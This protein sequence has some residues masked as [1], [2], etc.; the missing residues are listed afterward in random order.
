M[1]SF[2]QTACGEDAV[3]E[4]IPSYWQCDGDNDC[5]NNSDEENCEEKDCGPYAFNCGLEDSGRLCV[6]GSWECDGDDDCG[7]GADEA[8][9]D[10]VNDFFLFKYFLIHFYL[11][12]QENFECSKGFTCGEGSLQTC[13]SLQY[14]CDGDDDCGNGADEADCP[15]SA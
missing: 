5:G 12:L 3:R 11:Y 1:S 2:F 7:N 9:C 10:A 8:N 15:S 14:I 4:C 6:R 13:S